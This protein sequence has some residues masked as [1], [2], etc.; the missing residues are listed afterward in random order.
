MSVRKFYNIMETSGKS[1]NCYLVFQDLYGRKK[2]QVIVKVQTDA[3]NRSEIVI[4]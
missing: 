2:Q 3:H 1:L 4:S